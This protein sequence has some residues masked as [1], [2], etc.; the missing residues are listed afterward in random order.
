LRS[1]RSFPRASSSARASASYFRRLSSGSQFFGDRHALG[2][3]RKLAL[4]LRLDLA[5]VFIGQ[6]AGAAC[7][8]APDADGEAIRR[9]GEAEKSQ[10][11]DQSCENDSTKSRANANYLKNTIAKL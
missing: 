8:G 5:S 11:A 3:V 1:L 7:V 9:L 10:S 6:R 2:E 4:E